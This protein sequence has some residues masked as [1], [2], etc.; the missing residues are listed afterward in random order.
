MYGNVN[1]NVNGG[2]NYPYKSFRQ[3]LWDGAYVDYYILPQLKLV[4]V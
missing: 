4:L 3:N 2:A 1:V